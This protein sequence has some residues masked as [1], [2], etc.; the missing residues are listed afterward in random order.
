MHLWGAR[1]KDRAHP[2]MSSPT[3]LPLGRTME[4]T[5]HLT[6]QMQDKTLNRLLVKTTLYYV[7][8]LLYRW[9]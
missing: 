7:K 2:T 9:G 8:I 1:K 5:V 6:M 4:F 3:S